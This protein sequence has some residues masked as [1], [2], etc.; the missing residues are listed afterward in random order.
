MTLLPGWSSRQHRELHGPVEAAG[1]TSGSPVFA[2]RTALVVSASRGIGYAIATELARQGACVALT[3]RNGEPLRAAA[4]AIAEE[5]G[6]R[7]L[8][9]VAHSR[10]AAERQ[11]AVDAVMESFGRLDM[12]VYTTG[13]NP[14]MHTPVM[15]LDLESVRHTME[16]NVLGALGYTQLVW[17]S[18][19]KDHG[20]A[21]LMTSTVG[22]TGGFRLP[23]YSAS[24]AALNR[25]TQDMADQLAPRVRVNAVAPA[26]V[27]TSFM[28]TLITLP[29]DTIAASYPMGRIG[30]TGDI[31]HA[32]AFLLS[33]HASWIT[34][35][36]LPVDGGKSV[37][38]IT[39]DRAHPGPG[40]RIH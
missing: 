16:T 22:A 27:R 34:G 2:G 40:Q 8:P 39:H 12:L 31:A 26:F 1:H 24:K 4:C 7:V 9:L 37:A 19:M 29:H 20:G 6:S 23:A 32:A 21:I 18:W 13:I 25:L 11:A 38:A 36:T 5:T 3:A 33:P 17:H 10:K 30:E 15:E 35:V 28:E 14:A